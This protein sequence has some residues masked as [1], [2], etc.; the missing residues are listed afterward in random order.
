MNTKSTLTSLEAIR[1]ENRRMKS[2][3]K[4]R[5]SVVT[6]VIY[7]D[8]GLPLQVKLDWNCVA[9]SVYKEGSWTNYKTRIF[10]TR[11]AANVFANEKW[12][13]IK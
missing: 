11:E 5:I 13:K 6:G 4:A 8:D 9:W 7:D 2:S 12:S 10:E 1:I 3:A